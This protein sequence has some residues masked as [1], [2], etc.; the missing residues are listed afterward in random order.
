[1][2]V[3]MYVCMRACMCMEG[4]YEGDT[5]ADH[6]Q[7]GDDFAMMCCATHPDGLPQDG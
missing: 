5:Q 4:G 3:C 2:Y 7:E 6:V 1:M